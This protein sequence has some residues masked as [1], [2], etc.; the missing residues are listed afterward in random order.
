[1][2]TFNPEGSKPGNTRD[3]I[4]FAASRPLKRQVSSLLG[5]GT[6]CNVPG[7]TQFP[8]AVSTTLHSSCSSPGALQCLLAEGKWDMR[9]LAPSSFHEDGAGKSFRISNCGSYGWLRG[10]IPLIAEIPNGTA[11]RLQSTAKPLAIHTLRLR[12]TQT[13]TAPTSTRRTDQLARGCRTLATSLSVLSRFRRRRT[14]VDGQ[15][16]HRQV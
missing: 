9:V 11:T 3:S 16:R 8:S 10:S 7:S 2:R 15:S 12:R 4:E 1:M 14:E 5:C 6:S 13:A